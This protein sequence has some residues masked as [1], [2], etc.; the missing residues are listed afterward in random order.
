M[1]SHVR[2][3]VGKDFAGDKP[4]AMQRLAKPPEELKKARSRNSIPMKS[5]KS[6]PFCLF[7]SNT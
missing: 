7:E 2:S 1:L 6:Y 3:C 5:P 4:V